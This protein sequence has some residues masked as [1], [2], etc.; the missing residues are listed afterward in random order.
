LF[1]ITD[2]IAERARKVSGT[3]F[4]SIGDIAREQRILHNDADYVD[5]HDILAELRDNNLVVVSIMRQVHAVYKQY[6]DVAT[7]SL[8][9]VWSDAT[10]PRTWFLF[11]RTRVS[12]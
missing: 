4:R 3:T 7:T 2:P 10:E 1:A 12:S 6:A 5:P 8:L 11:E 9:E